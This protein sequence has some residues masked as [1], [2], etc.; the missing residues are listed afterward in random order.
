MMHTHDEGW[1]ADVV[2]TIAEMREHGGELPMGPGI[3]RPSNQR[4]LKRDIRAM[5]QFGYAFAVK[6]DDAGR[7]VRVRLL[8]V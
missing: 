7:L 4:A 3:L 2:D 1:I 6:R 5:R 8:E